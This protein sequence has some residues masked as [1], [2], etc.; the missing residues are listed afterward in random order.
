MGVSL[1]SQAQGRRLMAKLPDVKKVKKAIRDVLVTENLKLSNAVSGSLSTFSY[2]MKS[3][4]LLTVDVTRTVQ[5]GKFEAIMHDYEV[6]IDLKQDVN[7]LEEHCSKLLETLDDLEGPAREV[8]NVLRN[9]LQRKVKEKT[10]ISF[11][12]DSSETLPSIPPPRSNSDG[13]IQSN[14]KHLSDIERSQSDI[15]KSQSDEHLERKRKAQGISK[16]SSV[17]EEPSS[18]GNLDQHFSDIGGA[19]SLS[20][21]STLTTCTQEVANQMNVDSGISFTAG[22]AADDCTPP[23]SQADATITSPGAPDNYNVQIPITTTDSES[24]GVHIVPSNHVHSSTV[25]GSEKATLTNVANEIGKKPEPDESKQP[26]QASMDDEQTT[27]YSEYVPPS[28]TTCLPQLKT[29][30]AHST[31]SNCNHVEQLCEK[32]RQIKMLKKECR[33]LEEEL[34]TIKC[35]KDD[36]VKRKDT[37]IQRAEEAFKREVEQITRDR[38]EKIQEIE[39]RLEEKNKK[40]QEAKAKL[41]EKCDVEKEKDEEL[42]EVKKKF[43]DYRIKKCNELQEV[44]I[45]FEG[46]LQK[47][48]NEGKKI[49]KEMEELKEEKNDELKKS[50]QNLK[51]MKEEKN[52]EVQEIEKELEDKENQ[53]QEMKQKFKK[54][55]RD[56]ENKDDQLEEL[57]KQLKEQLKDLENRDNQLGELRRQLLKE[58]LKDKKNK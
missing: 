9:E 32:D 39:E 47:S 46:E 19:G 25:S 30:E 11:L 45:E 51:K 35:E 48:K 7:S 16:L 56:L 42:E 37:Q 58:Q 54:A 53:L 50:K 17:S 40:L 29:A 28:R 57:R 13:L 10:G 2:L 22:V 18:S 6:A 49:K 14:I 23:P 15:K 21:P 20:R 4:G 55:K 31:S 33:K 34:E 44:T 8:G 3:K 24:S 1:A 41:L 52:N 38:K 12:S 27:G 43:K 5:C 36:L 26:T